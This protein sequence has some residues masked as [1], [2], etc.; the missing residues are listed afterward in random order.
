MVPFSEFFKSKVISQFIANP[1]ATAIW[2]GLLLLFLCSFFI[3]FRY[4]YC[5]QSH[6]IEMSSLLN[7]A[8]KNLEQTLNASYNS[9]LA[10]AMTINN[11][12]LP[13]NFDKI[14]S[15]IIRLNP[16]I[17]II[18]LLPNGV[19][20]YVY[21]LQ[22]NESVLVYD[23]LN[24]TKNA[25]EAQ[26]AI[27]R[28]SV[29]FA[30]P[31]ELKQGGLAIAG[32]YPIYIKDKFWGFSSFL[33]RFDKLMNASG[34]YSI[35]HPN[36]YFQFSK[37]NPTTKIE[38]FFLSQPT[39]FAGNNYQKIL[40]PEGD[41]ALYIVDK[42]SDYHYLTELLPYITICFLL[43]SLVPYFIYVILKK[44]QELIL[45]NSIQEKK[46]QNSAAKYQIIFNKTSIAL[47]QINQQNHQ[48][49]EVNPQFCKLISDVGA[50][51]IGKSFLQLV[52]SEDAAQFNNCLQ[53][54]PTILNKSNSVRVRIKNYNDGYI[55]TQIVMSTMIDEN[56]GGK[57]IILAIENVSERKVAEDK[58]IQSE[59]QYKS[60]FQESPIALWEEDGSVVKEYFS[61]LGLMGRDR[62]FVQNY[63]ETNESIL[64]EIISRIKVININQECLNL[65]QAKDKDELITSFMSSMRLSP[66][67]GI[68]EMLVDI[69][70][71][72]TKGRT[73]G[74]VIFPDGR[75]AIYAM[76]WNIVEGYEE[77]FTRFIISTEDITVQVTSQK[78]IIASEQKLQSI[79]N[80]IDGIVWEYNPDTL[81]F[82]FVS[83]QSEKILGYTHNQW[84]N[85]VNF[86]NTHLHPDDQL[87]LTDY[88][89]EKIKERIPFNVEYR[90]IAKNGAIVW[91][92]DIINIHLQDNGAAILRGIMIDITFIK[93]NEV[94]LKQSL[95][96]VT[97]QNKRLLNFSYIVSHNLRS[98]TSNIQSLAQ[99]IRESE[100]INE[101]LE[102][103]HLVKTVSDDLNETITNLNEVINI[104][105]DV[106]LNVQNLL[107]VN[108]ILKTLEV[109]SEEIRQKNIKILGKIPPASLISYNRAYLQSILINVISNAIRYCKKIDEDRF[110]KF[111]YYEDVAY[112]VLEVQDN[113]IGI[114][115]QR[116]KNKLFGL[117]KTFSNN[118]DAKGI[119]LF[120]TKNQVEAMGGKIE[121]ESELNIGT[122]VRIFF[123]N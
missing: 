77:S 29:Y 57:S 73:Q 79:I 66:T 1:R 41:W 46:I 99:L 2:T 36:Y 61:Q 14:A 44:P 74:K 122:T 112:S 80:S 72:L 58:L 68:I 9:N 88:C 45:I 31:F 94:D 42:T 104:R 82:Q 53:T 62:D 121:I 92:R 34:I 91:F 93:E 101:Q 105:K 115:M 15:N 95:E 13:E 69:S 85:T 25:K 59:L 18:E 32:R 24:S 19:I 51:L 75:E 23:I 65:Y 11:E 63:L 71:G 83:I 21:P 28:R 22:T 5:K 43:I 113:G 114:N 60:L 117:Y 56:G 87:W 27:E 107:L 48:L 78:L 54:T 108:F 16:I 49:L 100:D 119:G 55:W 37:I 17:D 3:N 106:N 26:K 103:I 10:L 47:V 98:H 97:E 96:M 67:D 102:L 30:G 8:Q 33:I 40:I 116:N 52:H 70:Q 86:W 89:T 109:I 39:D 64:F 7:T 35:D 123:K 118:K 50:K 20:K 90:M 84:V 81:Q 110:I 6:A 120:I 4:E 76:T 38:E 111:S 12:G